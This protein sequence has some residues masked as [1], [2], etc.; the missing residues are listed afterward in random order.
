MVHDPLQLLPPLDDP[1][2][3]V[4]RGDRLA[5]LEDP[6][7]PARPVAVVVG[8]QVVGDADEPRPQGPSV[9]LSSRALEVPIR[10]EEGLLGDVLG[11]VVVA[12]AVVG[13][14]VDV[15]EMVAI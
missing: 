7:R 3:A 8:S 4:R 13:V 11:V 10:L 5:L 6:L 12:D 14:R 1:L 15:A 2:R 9:R